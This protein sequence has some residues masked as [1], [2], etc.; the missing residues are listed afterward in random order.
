MCDIFTPAFAELSFSLNIKIPAQPNHC[1]FRLQKPRKPLE[2]SKG[3]QKRV[4]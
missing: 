1:R 4:L 3:T 2:E